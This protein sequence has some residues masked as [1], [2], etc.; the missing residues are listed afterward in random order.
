MARSRFAGTRFESECVML[1]E[2]A[3][4]E[5]ECGD[6]WPPPYFGCGPSTSHGT[7]PSRLILVIDGSDEQ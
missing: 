3:S 5:V 6:G 2:M 4:V 1:A 7:R